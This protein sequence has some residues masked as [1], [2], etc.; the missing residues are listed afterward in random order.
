MK[1]EHGH[2]GELSG[3]RMGALNWGKEGFERFY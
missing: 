1:G 3:E 2:W